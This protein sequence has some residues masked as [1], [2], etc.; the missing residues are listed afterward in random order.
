MSARHPVSRATPTSVALAERDLIRDRLPFFAVVWSAV[1]I[2]WLIALAHHGAPFG[3]TGAA[4]IVGAQVVVLAT[5]VRLSGRVSSP[6]LMRLT[7]LVAIGCLGLVWTVAASLTDAPFDVVA[8]V[9]PVMVLIPPLFFAWG[10]GVELALMIG[11]GVQAAVWFG[12]VIPADDTSLFDIAVTASAG[13]GLGIAVAARVSH[14]FRLRVA[15]REQETVASRA[16]AEAHEAF[17]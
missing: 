4:A 11:L 14:E 13:A 5:A 10:W 16:L 3:V 15:R 1:T 9:M 17:R 8:I 6:A 7:A 12:F 2:L